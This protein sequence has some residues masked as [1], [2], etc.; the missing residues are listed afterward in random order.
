MGKNFTGEVLHFGAIRYRLTGSGTFKTNIISLYDTI[1]VAQPNI[2]MSISVPR[3]PTIL[4]NVNQQM[5]Y[6]YGRVEA[7]DEYFMVSRIV[8]YVRPVATG[9]PTS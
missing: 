4:T 6:V 5:A 2:T 7:I 1:S 8:V 3:E 9:Y